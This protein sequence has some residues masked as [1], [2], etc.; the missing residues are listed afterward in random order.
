MNEYK[1]L[2]LAWLTFLGQIINSLI[3]IANNLPV[4]Q[5]AAELFSNGQQKSVVPSIVVGI[6]LGILQAVLPR[7]Q[8]NKSK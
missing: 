5:N 7:I 2:I 4:S 8:K 1:K 3:L 6:G